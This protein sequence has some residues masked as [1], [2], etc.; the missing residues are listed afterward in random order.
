MVR[1][2]DCLLRHV[3]SFVEMD[4]ESSPALDGVVVRNPTWGCRCGTDG[5]FCSRAQFRGCGAAAPNRSRN[6]ASDEVNKRKKQND[7]KSSAQSGALAKAQRK[8]EE[9]QKQLQAGENAENGG[10]DGQKPQVYRWAKGMPKWM[11]PAVSS[12]VA[13]TSTVPSASDESSPAPDFGVLRQCAEALRAM[14][15]PSTSTVGGVAHCAGR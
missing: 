7:G 14:P 9:L 10:N 12:S 4:D 6:L 11:R 3:S 8:I 15:S 13:D 2:R 1:N 5:N